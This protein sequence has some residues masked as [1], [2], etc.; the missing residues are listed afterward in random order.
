[1]QIASHEL[2]SLHHRP[3]RRDLALYQLAVRSDVIGSVA[4][5]KPLNGSRS[6]QLTTVEVHPSPKSDRSRWEAAPG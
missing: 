1:M 5:K 4:I 3:P 2:L 6:T